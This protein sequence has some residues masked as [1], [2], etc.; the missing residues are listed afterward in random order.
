MKYILSKVGMT[1]DNKPVYSGVFNF[2]SE[3][4][5]PLDTIFLIS[6]DQKWVPCWTS[7]YKEAI[8]SG[9]KHDRII[10]KLYDALC[11]SY[12]MIYA[13]IICSKLEKLYENI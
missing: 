6:L 8:H 13:S 5:L 2:Y 10:S 3:H 1:S 7:F 11:D 9:M 12:G 4:G